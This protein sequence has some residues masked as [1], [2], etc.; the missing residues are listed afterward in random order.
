V[1]SGDKQ[2]TPPPLAGLRMTKFAAVRV[3]KA[4][5]ISSIILDSYGRVITQT[6]RCIQVTIPSLHAAIYRS[7]LGKPRVSAKQ[8]L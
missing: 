7:Y 6:L 1:N 5:S 8:K 2:T 3:L 4:G